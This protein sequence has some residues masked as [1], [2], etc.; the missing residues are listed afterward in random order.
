V[1]Q[2]YRRR[3]RAANW[4]TDPTCDRCRLIADCRELVAELAADLTAWRADVAPDRHRPR[5]VLDVRRD[6][7]CPRHVHGKRGRHAHG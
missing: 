4:V 6:P 7:R 3:Q 2:D 1:S 5:Q